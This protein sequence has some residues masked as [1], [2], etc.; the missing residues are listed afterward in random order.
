MK[1]LIIGK[2]GE[3]SVAV[4]DTSNMIVPLTVLYDKYSYP[5]RKAVDYLEDVL[6]EWAKKEETLYYELELHEGGDIE[7]Y[8]AHK[9]T[10]DLYKAVFSGDNGMEEVLVYFFQN[11]VRDMWE[12]SE[13]AYR[14]AKYLIRI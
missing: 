4:I 14:D 3:N 7:V 1:V 12:N 6:W 2:C 13:E 8:N 9:D 5:K 11:S 10:H